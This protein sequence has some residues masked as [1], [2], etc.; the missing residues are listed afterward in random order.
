[1]QTRRSRAW[2]TNPDYYR[3]GYANV[4]KLNGLNP[5]LV[6]DDRILDSLFNF[7]GGLNPEDFSVFEDNTY[8]GRPLPD[9]LL[10]GLRSAVFQGG[11]STGAPSAAAP[12]AIA[13]RPT[14]S[15]GPDPWGEPPTAATPA[16]N[17]VRLEAAQIGGAPTVPGAGG[18]VTA[19]P[20]VPSAAE[21]LGAALETAPAPELATAT[22]MA[23]QLLEDPKKDLRQLPPT[24]RGAAAPSSPPSPPGGGGGDGPVDLIT[25][26]RL[27][28]Q[29]GKRQQLV[30]QAADVVNEADLG[31][32]AADLGVGAWIKQAGARAAAG[33]HPTTAAGHTL[34]GVMAG[35]SKLLGTGVQ[36]LPWVA[37]AAPA[38]MGAM[39][40]AQSGTGGAV[41]QGGGAGIGSVI[42]GVIGTAVA[43]PGL[44][45]VVGAGLGG[46][47][48]NA[49]GGMGRQAAVSAVEAAQG[50]D[51]G[52]S[53]QIGRSL[54]GVIDTPM[55]IESRQMVAQ[56]NSPAVLAIKAEERQRSAAQRAQAA[57]DLLMQAY[58]RGLS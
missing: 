51:T 36:A 37:A 40:G 10:G 33:M 15:I 38:V 6:D 54:D 17:Q 49:A 19:T 22:E 41:I 47:L 32:L 43:G 28:R 55:E 31:Y 50:G 1:M 12:T 35:G 34:K 45:T 14:T 57:Q 4:L 16:A 26:E 25:G 5:A 18:P 3:Q 58:A 53:G 52:L 29:G 42:G 13:P 48:G 9:N 24:V 21:Q 56:M 20:G 30:Q 2:E 8:K 44:G 46:M 23:A 7:K 39:E 11:F 27:R